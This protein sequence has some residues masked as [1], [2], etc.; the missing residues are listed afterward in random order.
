MERATPV[1]ALW[2]GVLAQ[3]QAK[4]DESAAQIKAILYFF[5]TQ[6]LLIHN[7]LSCH[8]NIDA[9]QPKAKKFGTDR[10]QSRYIRGSVL[11]P[12][13][14]EDKMMAYYT[15]R[16]GVFVCVRQ[17]G[18]VV[19]KRFFA[20]FAAVLLV[21]T[22]LPENGFAEGGKG[23][24]QKATE[25]GAEVSGFFMMLADVAKGDVSCA[26]IARKLKD[27]DNPAKLNAY[28]DR[29]S[30][31]GK[32]LQTFPE[33]VLEVVNQRMMED[34]KAASRLFETRVKKCE[35]ASEMAAIEA[36]W[37]R[38][39]DYVFDIEED[40]KEAEAA[41]QA[42][43]DAADVQRNKLVAALTRPTCP[44]ILKALEALDTPAWHIEYKNI[45]KRWND[46]PLEVRREAVARHQRA[47]EKRMNSAVEELVVKCEGDG[48]V[49]GLI[50]NIVGRLAGEE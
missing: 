4:M 36:S 21:G 13:W 15:M 26:E 10:A 47:W 19:M 50:I 43:M 2:W 14:L 41:V 5:K 16:E 11:N 48:K 45:V 40:P 28:K 18:G 27:L 24:P 9:L 7:N 20:I 31:A 3:A 33:A 42:A 30:K 49:F 17:V 8:Q 34:S 12:L 6:L 32:T 23:V 37:A 1:S 39:V 22:T 44:E 38:I 46:L 25:A 29:L 35:N